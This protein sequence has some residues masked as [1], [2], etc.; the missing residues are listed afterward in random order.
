MPSCNDY[1]STILESLKKNKIEDKTILI[2]FSDHGTSLGERKREKNF[3][4]Y[5]HMIILSKFFVF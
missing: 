2:F 4:A 3:M 1:V 5:L